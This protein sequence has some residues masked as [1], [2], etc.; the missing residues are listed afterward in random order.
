[1]DDDVRMGI[2]RSEI[3]AR[4]RAICSN[5]SEKEFAGLVEDIAR[6]TRKSEKRSQLWGPRDG[7]K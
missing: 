3:S 4:L 6:N 1:M 7:S 2:L 5:M